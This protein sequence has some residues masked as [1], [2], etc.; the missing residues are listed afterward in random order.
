M[1]ILVSTISAPA[2]DDLK[3][4]YIS[5]DKAAGLDDDGGWYIKA[6][7]D[8]DILIGYGADGSSV[9]MKEIYSYE[10]LHQDI[11]KFME[12]MP[13]KKAGD[14]EI[15]IYLEPMDYKEGVSPQLRYEHYP[16]VKLWNDLMIKLLPAIFAGPE[17]VSMFN[18]L[19]EKSR[20]SPFKP[21]TGRE[22][23]PVFQIKYYH[24]SH[25]KD[26]IHQIMLNLTPEQRVALGHPA[27]YLV[28]NS[29]ENKTRPAREPGSHEHAKQIQ[30]LENPKIAEADEAKATKYKGWLL[31]VAGGLVLLGLLVISLKA[32]RTT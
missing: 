12:T 23:F 27:E 13:P 30:Q 18:R 4:K 2:A 8:G 20:Y 19:Q 32:K 26:R 17:E 22:K 14:P 16:A 9:V 21:I 7:P 24:L 28:E 6:Q 1:L 15:S 3:F 25:R 5:L 11:V 29:K 10:Q 31:V